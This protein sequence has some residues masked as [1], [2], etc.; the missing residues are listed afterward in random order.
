MNYYMEEIL[1]IS[2]IF[3]GKSPDFRRIDKKM[4]K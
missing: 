2:E 3:F 4:I 1:I